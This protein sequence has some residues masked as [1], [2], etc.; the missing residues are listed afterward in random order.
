MQKIYIFLIP[1][2]MSL[3]C[4]KRDEDRSSNNNQDKIKSSL[5][6]YEKEKL[7]KPC[8]G[9]FRL[10]P[11]S[12]IA[13]LEVGEVIQVCFNQELVGRM[14]VNY[15]SNVKLLESPSPYEIRLVVVK[16][17]PIKI[18]VKSSRKDGGSHSDLATYGREPENDPI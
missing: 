13:P 16:S 15:D 2:L 8:E 1:F 5:K 10:E 11:K 14:A 17:G 9:V 18:R 7:L 12:R 4:G 3:S 6:I